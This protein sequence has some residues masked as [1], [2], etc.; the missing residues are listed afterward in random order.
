MTQPAPSDFPTDPAEARAVQEA[1]RGRVRLDPFS[2]PVARV[3]GVDAAFLGDHVVAAAVL[4]RYPELIVEQEATATA[5]VPLP[6]IPGLLSFREGPAVLA[7]LERLA[8]VPDLYLFD[9][10]GIA[11]P[12][13]LGIAAHLGVLLDRPAIGVA[14]SR[15]TGEVDEAALGEDKG[16]WLPITADDDTIGALVRSRRRVRP[17]YV[18]PGHRCT[19]TDAVAWTLACCTRYRLPEPTRA[20]DALAAREKRRLAAATH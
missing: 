3:V 17:L 14:K 18:S 7:A 5:P 10:Q 16:E 11:H 9:G 2:G 6:Y 19:V 20:A 1:L 8:A 13:R 15:L 4:M 12:R